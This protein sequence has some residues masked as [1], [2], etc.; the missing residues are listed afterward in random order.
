MI[1]IDLSGKVI[2]LADGNSELSESIA[3]ELV[4]TGA[5]VWVVGNKEH[6]DCDQSGYASAAVDWSSVED[7]EA[8]LNDIIRTEGRIDCLINN[9]GKQ[10]HKSLLEMTASEWDEVLS[11]NLDGGYFA[12]KAVAPY[13]K[14]EKHG[15][16]INISAA[17]AR[18]GEVDVAFAASKSALDSMTQGLCKE[19]GDYGITVNGLAP[20][21]EDPK[22]PVSD[23]AKMVI[24]LCSSIISSLHG[25]TILLDYGKS[26]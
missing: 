16:I 10:I 5:N 8:K 18:N 13:M 17:A 11:Y 26:I 1:H 22:T 7:V 24:L 2:L 12:C 20:R 19:L 15:A 23:I 9:F 3:K 21:Y 4:K 14:K 25:Q 6:V